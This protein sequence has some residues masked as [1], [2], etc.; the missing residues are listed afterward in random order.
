MSATHNN[1]DPAEVAK[2]DALASSWWD[3]EGE[4]K[5][6]HQLNPVRLS[7]IDSRSPLMVNMLLM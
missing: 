3:E 6:L 7:Y 2:F 4:S 5:P 1:V